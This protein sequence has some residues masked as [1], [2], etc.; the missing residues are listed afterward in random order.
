MKKAGKFIIYFLLLL[1]VVIGFG[2][3][4]V[5]WA[6]PNVGKP[7]KL[8]IQQT[9]SRLAR[10]KYLAKNITLCVDCHSQR[11]WTKFAGPPIASTFG[12]GGEKFDESIGFPGSVYSSNITPF[13]LKNWTDGELFRM[14]TTGVTKDGHAAMNIMPYPAYG[15]MDREDIYSII[16]Y[17]RTL[18]SIEA[19]VPERKLNFPVNFIVNTIPKKANLQKLPNPSDTVRYG[20][21]LVNAAACIDCHTKNE[22]GNPVEGMDFAG[23]RL[24]A[25]PAGNLYSTNITPDTLTGIGN[26]SKQDFI[27]R[28]KMYQNDH[29]SPLNGKQFQTVMPWIMYANIEESDLAAMYSY[30]R[31]V[32][33]IKNQVVRFVPK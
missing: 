29:S 17:I 13:N 30:L 20:G 21:Y 2:L 24:F 9:P 32:K 7:E 12:K 3:G 22:K 26:W 4:Y 31:T 16:A 33:P 11:D 23:S 19:A 18:P 8:V 27:N 28:F 25:S 10:G 5:K 14:I 6:L 1:F 15:R